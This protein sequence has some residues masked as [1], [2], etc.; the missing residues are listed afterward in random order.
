MGMG[1]SKKNTQCEAK[2]PDGVVKPAN[3]AL[4][5]ALMQDSELSTIDKATTNLRNTRK[6]GNVAI[7][8]QETGFNIWDLAG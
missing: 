3:L 6:E 4:T 2:A 1:K 8:G 7:F 5:R